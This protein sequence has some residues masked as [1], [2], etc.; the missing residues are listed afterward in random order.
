MDRQLRQTTKF[1][2]I[3]QALNPQLQSTLNKVHVT[4]T[5]Q[6]IDPVTGQVQ[7]IQKVAVIDTKAELESRIL[8]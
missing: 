8:V 7:F 3:R 1:C 5:A 6:Y 2:H 4:T